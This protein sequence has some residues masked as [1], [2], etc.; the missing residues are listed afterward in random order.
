MC[1]YAE[2]TDDGNLFNSAFLINYDL[3]Q[4][5]NT[6]KV[7]LFGDDKKWAT[8]EETVS[9]IEHNFKSFTLKFPRLEKE[10]K[11]GLGICMDI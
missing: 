10:V 2:K 4:I 1:G 8:V 7:F 5:H 6:R 3:A 11:V 9:G